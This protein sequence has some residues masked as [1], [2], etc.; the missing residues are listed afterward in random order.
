V[1]GQLQLNQGAIISF[2]SGAPAAN[3]EA[4]RNVVSLMV[5]IASRVRKA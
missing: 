2:D 3:S 5:A 4:L 1:P